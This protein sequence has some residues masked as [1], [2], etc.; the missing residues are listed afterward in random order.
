MPFR[1]IPAL[2]CILILAGCAS[3]EPQNASYAPLPA[4]TAVM[5]AAPPAQP[6]AYGQAGQAPSNEP[7]P[8]QPTPGCSTVDG[9]TL[10]DVPTDAASDDS[11]GAYV[12]NTN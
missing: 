12:H 10:C 5:P 7:M 6:T 4:P 3:A 9:V 11:S 2:C 1:A 8:P